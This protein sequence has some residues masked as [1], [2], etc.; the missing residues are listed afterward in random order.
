MEV[1]HAGDGHG[2][3]VGADER[4]A[5]TAFVK[6]HQCEEV[7][8]LVGKIFLRLPDGG[9]GL[10]DAADGHLLQATHRAAL[11]DDDEVVDVGL[12]GVNSLYIPVLV[13]LDL[14]VH[15]NNVLK[16]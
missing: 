5:A 7:L 12:V 1:M 16:C 2:I 9:D 6:A 11:I 14:I 15:S 10:V 4:H 13:V 3:D 8:L